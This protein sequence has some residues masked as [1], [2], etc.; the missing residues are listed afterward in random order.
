VRRRADYRLPALL[1]LIIPFTSSAS[2]A[3]EATHPARV[4]ASAARAALPVPALVRAAAAGAVSA[5]DVVEGDVMWVRTT[6]D[7]YYGSSATGYHDKDV[8]IYVVQL[9]G[10]FIAE[11]IP[12]PIWNKGDGTVSLP[13]YPEGEELR[14]IVPLLDASNFGGG[15]ELGISNPVGLDAFGPVGAFSLG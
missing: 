11:G 3:T 10:H 15:E 2:S 12:L 13:D 8:P 7:A 5:E 1:L 14:L 6:T 9:R 4:V